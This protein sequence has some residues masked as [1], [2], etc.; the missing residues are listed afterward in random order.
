MSK[1][2]RFSERHAA[3]G[4]RG[5]IYPNIKSTQHRKAAWAQ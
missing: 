1:K 3:A 4:S 2:A 5:Q